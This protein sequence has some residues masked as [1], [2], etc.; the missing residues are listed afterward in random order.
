MKKLQ[1]HNLADMGS[2]A[3]IILEF[4][5]ELGADLTIVGSRGH[6]RLAGFLMGSVSQT[7]G[8]QARCHCLVVR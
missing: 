7:L 6:G 5:D 1:T 3:Q 4:A 2:A 8:Q